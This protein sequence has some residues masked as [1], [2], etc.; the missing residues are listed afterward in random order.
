VLVGLTVVFV[1][2]VVFEGYY[3]VTYHTFDWRTAPPRI[4][5]CGRDYDRGSSISTS[6]VRQQFKLHRVRTVPPLFRALYAEVEPRPPAG[7][8]VCTMTLYYATSSNRL[9]SYVL[10]GGP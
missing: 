2:A 6:L 3:R 5:Y 7:T 4:G 1:G 10:S 9:V 8:P